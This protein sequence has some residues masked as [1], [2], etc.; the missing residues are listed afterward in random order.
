[1]ADN[2]YGRICSAIEYAMERLRKGPKER[3]SDETERQYE[4]RITT[5]YDSKHRF[6]LFGIRCLRG[7]D[8]A[9][10][11]YYLTELRQLEDEI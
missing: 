4:I 5:W 11:D 1:M 8:K 10:A 9:R 2:Q 6:L 7:L 3:M